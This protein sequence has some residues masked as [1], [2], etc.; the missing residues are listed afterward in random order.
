MNFPKQGLFVILASYT[1]FVSPKLS[2]IAIDEGTNSQKPLKMELMPIQQEA[3]PKEW[4]VFH[5]LNATQREAVWS[6]HANKGRQLKHW[7]WTWRIAW[8]RHCSQS[9]KAYCSKI[10]NEGS[11][12][13]AA[14]V[15]AETA[16][17]LA[18]RFEGTGA[19]YPA[20]IET[21]TQSYKLPQNTRN[22]VPLFVRFRILAALHK[23]MGNDGQAVIK[24]L[25]AEHEMTEKYYASLKKVE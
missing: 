17:R 7:H 6:Y 22:G 2:A 18:D 13:Q 1:F 16:N 9:M 8:I 23:I 14:V 15:R 3:N 25:A 24:K 19:K 10:L 5:G 12:D 21:L 20:V 4:Q 11:K